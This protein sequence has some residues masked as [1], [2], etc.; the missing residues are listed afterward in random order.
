RFQTRN[1]DQPRLRGEKAAYDLLKPRGLP[2]PDAVVLDESR[3]IVPFD[4]LV[5]SRLPGAPVIDSW[6]ALSPSQRHRIAIEAGTI[7]AR[8]HETIVESFGD[9]CN[10]SVCI[11]Q[12][13]NAYL[14]D[15]VE[16]HVRMAL[17]QRLLDRATICRLRQLIV[18]LT[19]SL[20][21]DQEP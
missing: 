7:H 6:P 16:R 5:T 19:P 9:L 4:Y 14:S 10:A 11:F 20:E 17:D 1:S 12:T 3:S 2:I 18:R 13:W 21:Y 15:Y 8:I